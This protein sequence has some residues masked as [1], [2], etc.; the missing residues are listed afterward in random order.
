MKRDELPFEDEPENTW[1][2]FW[3]FGPRMRL[4]PHGGAPKNNAILR[5]RYALNNFLDNGGKPLEKFGGRGDQH[6]AT[7][8]E[9][10][11]G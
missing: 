2:A 1:G 8:H 7:L 6:F 11:P 10:T 3:C 9:Y 4:R 5:K